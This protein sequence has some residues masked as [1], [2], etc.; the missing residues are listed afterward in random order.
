LQLAPATRPRDATTGV[1]SPQYAGDRFQDD[2]NPPPTSTKKPTKSVG[3]KVDAYT[4]VWQKAYYLATATVGYPVKLF[5]RQKINLN[6][7]ITNLFNYDVPLYNTSGPPR[8]ERRSGVARPRLLS[9]LLQLHRPA[10]FPPVGD[11]HVL[12][13]RLETMTAMAP[14]PGSFFLFWNIAVAFA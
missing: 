12:A 2:F 11:H 3:G 5:G 9:A 8:R 13:P 1:A 6:L 4:V 10:Q 7:S 14:K